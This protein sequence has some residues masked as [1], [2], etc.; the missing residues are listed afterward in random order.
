MFFY[1]WFVP[2]LVVF[3]LAAIAFYVTVKNR[4]GA[5]IRTTGRVLFHKPDDDEPPSSAVN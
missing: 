1:E 3:V 5:G 2:T 4:T